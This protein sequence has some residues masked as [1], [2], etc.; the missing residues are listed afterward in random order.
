VLTSA[1][2][3]ASASAEAEAAAAEAEA[4]E[5]EAEA[6]AEVAE[7]AAGCSEPAPAGVAVELRAASG[8]TGPAVA[9]A[10]RRAGTPVAARIADHRG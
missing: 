6:A 10:G 2:G 3:P 7:P 5:A 8:A 1:R 9:G 4:A